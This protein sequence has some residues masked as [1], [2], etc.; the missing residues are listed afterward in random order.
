[1][2]GRGKQTGK[3]AGARLG[4][5]VK[6]AI[7]PGVTP[8][9]SGQRQITPGRSAMEFQCP[10]CINRAGGF[11]PA[12]RTQPR[13]QQQPV[14]FDQIHQKPRHLRY[15]DS[16]RAAALANSCCSS[17]RTV[18]FSAAELALG[19]SVRSNPLRKRTT[20]AACRNAC[21]KSRPSV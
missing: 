7:A 1:M 6:P 17:L 2:S 15:P 9:D 13:A 10:Q 12:R 14:S 4:H 3:Q 21:S 19:K 20:W 11:K 18:A 8:S 5:R 16:G